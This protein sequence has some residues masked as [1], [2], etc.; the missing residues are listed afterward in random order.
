MTQQPP[1]SRFLH[2]PVR[3]GTDG[4]LRSDPDGLRTSAESILRE[5]AFVLHVTRSVRTA[6][7]EEGVTRRQFFSTRRRDDEGTGV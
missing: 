5:M 7:M 4:R 2:Q 6:W 1:P 3:R